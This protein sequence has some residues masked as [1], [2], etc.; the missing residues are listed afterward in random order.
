MYQLLHTIHPTIEMQCLHI[1]SSLEHPSFLNV[2]IDKNIIY[3]ERSG[4]QTKFTK[5]PWNIQHVSMSLL[6]K[7]SYVEKDLV[8]KT[9]FTKWHHKKFETYNNYE[10]SYLYFQCATKPKPENGLTLSSL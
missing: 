5:W 7:K 8:S 2:F 1:F 9:Q 3:G 10:P 4:D 6:I